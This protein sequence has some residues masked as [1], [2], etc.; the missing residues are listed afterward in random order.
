MSSPTFGRSTLMTS[1]PKSASICA[2]QGPASWRLRS[3]TWMWESGDFIDVC[4][5]EGGY[6]SARTQETA[7]VGLA[8]FGEGARAFL[9]LRRPEVGCNHHAAVG[10]AL[11]Q[12]VFKFAHERCLEHA[13]HGG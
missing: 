3:S 9:L 10:I 1:A 8:L 12:Q 6:G 13:Y 5:L 2:D 11:A 7:E 4:V